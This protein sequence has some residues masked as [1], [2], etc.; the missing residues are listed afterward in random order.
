MSGDHLRFRQ[1]LL[2]DPELCG[3]ILADAEHFPPVAAEPKRVLIRTDAEHLDRAMARG[4]AL[5]ALHS[6]IAELQLIGGVDAA[7]KS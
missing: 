2:A 1:E 6:E 3:R 4:F 5:A 7:N